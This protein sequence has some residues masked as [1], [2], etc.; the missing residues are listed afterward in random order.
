MPR[1]RLRFVSSLLCSALLL[2][3]SGRALAHA[4]ID[5]IEAQVGALINAQR[6]AAGLSQLGLDD[7]LS[8]VADQHSSDMATNGC[9]S[10]DSCDG[11]SWADRI[12]TVYPQFSAIGE[13]IAAGYPGPA[14]VVEAW[15]NSPGHRDQILGASFQG[16]GIGMVE[17]GSYGIYWT[18]NF[19]GLTPVTAAVPEPG[20]MALMALGLGG[21]MLGRRR[22]NASAP[23]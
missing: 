22:R 18:V 15:M 13:I 4:V 20:S 17:G 9:F 14:S 12:H 6:L 2:L 3:G 1:I 19:G 16:F 11:T 8:F 10:H 21:L 23:S 7:R 5:D